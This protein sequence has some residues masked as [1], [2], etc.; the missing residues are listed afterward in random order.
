MLKKIATYYH[1]LKHLR[2]IQFQY[3]AYYFFRKKWRKITKFKYVL[4]VKSQI[5]TDFKLEDSIPQHKTWIEGNNFTFLNQNFD[6]KSKIDWNCATYGKL[7][8]Y[9]LC[10][11]EYLA[12]DSLSKDEGVRLIRSFI[13]DLWVAKD[14]VEPFPTALRIMYWVKFLAKHQIND[15]QINDSLLAQAAILSDNLEYHI[16]GNHLAE[17]GFGLLF[18]AY[19]FKNDALYKIAKKIVIAELEEEIL[20]DGGH[21]ER[22]TM[23]HQHILFRVLDGINLVRNNGFQQQELLSF[24][25]QQAGIML[26]W[27]EKMTFRNGDIPM[28]NDAAPHIAPSS[29]DLFDYA[30]RLNIPIKSVT[31]RES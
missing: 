9:N 1:T 23:Y 24:L 4:S 26:G 31:L 8:V 14:A 6:F 30:K 28:V 10:Y 15:A 11:F 22:S 25:T 21:F 16:L 29:L 3:R 20:P 12:Q 5:N 2:P 7:W 18:A 13:A 19:Y 27:L 17:D